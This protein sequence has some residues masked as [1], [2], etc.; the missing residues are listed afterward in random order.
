MEDIE[1][2]NL[3]FGYE[4]Q[5]AGTLEKGSF[6]TRIVPETFK[7]REGQVSVHVDVFELL[8]CLIQEGKVQDL[9]SL[10]ATLSTG[11]ILTSEQFQAPDIPRQVGEY[12]IA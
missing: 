3:S 7:A 4:K 12:I 11:E 9:E 1:E 2:I 8:V 6:S 5:R 10:Q